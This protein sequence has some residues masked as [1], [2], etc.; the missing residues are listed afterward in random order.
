[1]EPRLRPDPLPV[2]EQKRFTILTR[3]EPQKQLEHAIQAFALVLK[4]E[5]DAKLDI[6][7]DGAERLMLENEIAKLGVGSSVTLKGHD[8]SAR[9][10]LWS[11]TG[12]LMSSRF[13]GYPLATLE[14]MS[15]GCPVISYDIKYGPREQI[16]HGVDGYLVEPGDVQG[17]ADR[18]VEM[19][20][21]PALV[22]RMSEAAFDKAEAHGHVAFL[23]DWRHALNEVIR[24]KDRRTRL[25]SV[26]LTVT[27]LGYA[28][29]L[30]AP[31]H[32]AA[33]HLPEGLS[34][35]RLAAQ[36][37][38]QSSSS[39]LVPGGAADEVRRQTQCGRYQQDVHAGRCNHHTRRHLR[40]LRINSVDSSAGKT[41]R[42]HVRRVSVVR[43]CSMLRLDGGHRVRGALPTPP[44]VEQLEL[45]DLSRPSEELGREL[46][47]FL[48]LQRGTD[49][50][51]W[52]GRTSIARVR[53]L[54]RGVTDIDE[55]PNYACWPGGTGCHPKATVTSAMKESPCKP[56]PLFCG[57]GCVPTFRPG[58][59][60]RSGGQGRRGSRSAP[61]SRLRTAAEVVRHG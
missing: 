51:A 21:N 49:H 26:K 45:A 41:Q 3:L 60:S 10:A 54:S 17:M 4:E 7:G 42:R 30:S 19:I 38:G 50:A 24:K 55:K 59:P 47:G 16:T 37:A 1:M 13:E 48:R 23:K 22:A 44:G 53:T 14:S 11:A 35:V 33:S 6:Y 8:P 39:S 15:H 61:S 27:Q 18:V 25:R 2:R 56:W 20:R 31:V 57:G 43:S 46:R 40:R 12:F 29:G 52:I 34:K 32:R 58:T 36:L 5:P 28:Q 9:Q